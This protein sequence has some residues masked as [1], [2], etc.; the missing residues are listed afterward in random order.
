MNIVYLAFGSNIIYHLQTYFSLISLLRFKR[1]TDY[2]T[3]Y[4]DK[5][6]CYKRLE[7]YVNLSVL[8]R[9]TLNEWINGTGYIFRAKIK[10]IE[11]SAARYPT[12]HLLFMDGDTVLSR[13]G[14]KDMQAVLDEGKGLMY[15]D[16][17]HPSH[18]AGASLRMWKA[19]KGVQIED[20]V[21]SLKHNDWNSGV[22]GIPAKQ[23]TPV[24]RLALA[25]CDIILAKKVRCF[26]AEQYAFSIAM[27]EKT[28]V[29]AATPWVLHYWGNKEE[30]HK[31]INEFMIT[32]YL[33]G[34]SV[35]QDIS[36][37]K[38]FPFEKIRLYVRKSNTKRRLL[39]L[40]DKLF[41]D[42]NS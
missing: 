1:N 37:L 2:I 22:I 14:L 18:M 24:I 28:K 41:P 36:S 10:A 31:Y 8:D 3:V 21:V 23:L 38:D 33:S 20:C 39:R 34:A 12:Q 5:P 29:Q 32:S 6:Q 42:R 7:S 26:T 35:E 9:K 11:D 30:W 13:N 40:V 27:Q 4:T 15:T 25:A 17:G 19:M 16:E